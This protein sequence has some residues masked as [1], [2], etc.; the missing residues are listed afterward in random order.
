MREAFLSMNVVGSFGRYAESQFQKIERS[1]H[2]NRAIAE[3]LEAIESK[4]LSDAETAASFLK[5]KGVAPTLGRAKDEVKAVYRSFFDRGLLPQSTFESLVRAVAEGRRK[6]LQPAPHRPKN[7]YN[8]LRLLHSCLHLLREGEPLIQVEGEL[9]ETL[10]A[11]KKQQVPL[12][13]VLGRARLLAKEI[14]AESKVS[15]LPEK[16]DF[17]AADEFLKLCR[18]ESA[19]A[20]LGLGSARTFPAGTQAPD[21]LHPTFLPVPLPPDIRPDALRRFLED[22]PIREGRLLWLALSGAHAY[23]FPSEDSDLDLK[24]VHVIPAGKLLGLDE[25]NEAIDRITLWEGREHDFTTNEVGHVARLLLRGNGNMF[26][27]F[28]GPLPLVTT[29]AGHRL[30]KIAQGALSLRVFHHYAG[31]FQGMVREYRTEAAAGVRKAKRLLYGYRVALTGIHLLLEG[32]M[33]T[34][35]LALH[36]RYGFPAVPEL[37][38]V[39]RARETETILEADEPKYLGDLARLERLLEDARSSSVLPEEPPNRSELEELVVK[40]RLVL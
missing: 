12:A 14:D 25:A 20:S 22:P 32:E 4:E 9:R 11:V 15:K 33:V 6:S 35:L 19:R 8:L 24:G 7:A 31:F 10:L 29:P 40:L 23:G 38:A 36:E 26:E 3:L 1:E 27:R 37:V 28:L 18:R 34:N 2:R 17:T 39:K 30:R 13:D 21:E 16:P 5:K